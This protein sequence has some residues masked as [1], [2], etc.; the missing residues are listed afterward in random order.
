MRT[1]SKICG[2]TLI[3]VIVA[4]VVSAIAMAAILPFLGRV[5]QLGHEPRT[6]LQAGLDLQTAMERLVA[7]DMAQGHDPLALQAH[8]GAGTYDGQR[9]LENNFVA[10][11]NGVETATADRELLKVVLQSPGTQETMERLFAVPP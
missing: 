10:Y 5:F 7:W 4:M 1:R 3:E 11:R 6:S 9:V 8:I 2:Y